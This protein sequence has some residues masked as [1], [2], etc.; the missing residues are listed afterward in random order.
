M[1]LILLLIISSISLILTAQKQ[2]LQLS[3]SSKTI[4]VGKAISFTV[5]SS[6]NGTINIEFPSCF[7]SGGTMNSMQQTIDS[8]G[9]LISSISYTQE[10]SFKKEGKFTL[11]ATLKNGS[12]TY[13]SNSIT[14]TITKKEEN[15]KPKKS[16]G[17]SEWD[18]SK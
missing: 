6:I 17:N 3:S 11:S 13:K 18:I 8:R 5:N 14:V 2:S 16:L 10:G 7:M 15:Q 12:K 9:N 1:K 4:E